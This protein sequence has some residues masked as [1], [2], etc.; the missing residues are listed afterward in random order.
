M[1][2]ERW[3]VYHDVLVGYAFDVPGFSDGTRIMTE[4]KHKIDLDSMTA[5]CKDGTYKLGDFGTYA[6]HQ[7]PEL[8][9]GESNGTI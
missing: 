8:G 7:Q 1:K 3:I 2:L 5:F 6:E 4:F 9:K